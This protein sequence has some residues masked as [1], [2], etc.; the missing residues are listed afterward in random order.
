M[1]E[2]WGQEDGLSLSWMG[3]DAAVLH[4]NSTGSICLNSSSAILADDS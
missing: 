4:K 1:Q 3:R 2:V